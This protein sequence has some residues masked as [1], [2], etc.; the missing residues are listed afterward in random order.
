VLDWTEDASKYF[1]RMKASLGK[2]GTPMDDFDIAG[3]A[4]ALAHGAEVITANLVHFSR[5]GGLVCRH[6]VE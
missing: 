1:G 6:W 4:V 2:S 5:I 3:A